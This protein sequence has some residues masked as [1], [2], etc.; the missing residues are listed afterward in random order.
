MKW[1]EPRLRTVVF[2]EWKNN[3]S[4]IIFTDKRTKK[5]RDKELN[6][7]VEILWLF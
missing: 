1:N 3:T 7:S 6:K 2:R 4:M 5:V